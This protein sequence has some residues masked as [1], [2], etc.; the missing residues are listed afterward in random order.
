MRPGIGIQQQQQQHQA[1]SGSNPFNV[2]RLLALDPDNKTQHRQHY[3]NNYHNIN[4]HTQQHHHHHQHHQQHNNSRHQQH[5]GPQQR[6]TSNGAVARSSSNPPPIPHSHEPPPLQQHIPS[7]HRAMHHN[8]HQYDPHCGAAPHTQSV[9]INTEHTLHQQPIHVSSTSPGPAMTGNSSQSSESYLPDLVRGVRSRGSLASG[10]RE[11]SDTSSAYSGS[12]TMCHSVH[13][14]DHDDVDLS[15]LMESVVDSD[16]EDLAETI[17]TMAVRDAVRECLEKDPSERT[18]DDIKV[19]LEFTQRLKAFADKTLAVRRAMCQAMVFAVVEDAGTVLMNDGE[20]LDSWSVIINGHVQVMTSTGSYELHLGDSFGIPPTMDKLHH[21]GVMRSMVDDCQFVCIRQSDYYSI[22]HQGEENTQKVEEDGKLVL[23][24]EQR[25]I[26]AMNRKG[27]IVIKGTP[28]RLMLQLIEVENCIDPTYVEDFLLT[29]RTFLKSPLVVAEKLL[30]WFENQSLRNLVTRVVLL[31]VNNH[32]TDFEMDPVMMNFLEQFEEGLERSKMEGQLRLLDF[33]CAAKARSRTVTLTRPSR[34][35]I[36]HFSILGGL[37]KPYGI[38]ISKVEKGSKAEEVGLKRGDQILEVNGQS[39]EQIEHARAL[40]ILRS[41]CHLAI[42]VKSN[43]LAFKEMLQTPNTSPR[44]HHRKTSDVSSGSGHSNKSVSAEFASTLNLVNTL[45]SPRSKKDPNNHKAAFMT[46]KA[47]WLKDAIKNLLPKNSQLESGAHSDESV[48]SQSSSVGGAAFHSHSNPDLTAIPYEETRQEFPEHVLKVMSCSSGCSLV[49]V[50]VFSC[51]YE[52]TR[53][54][55]PEHV[56]K[57]MVFSCSY[58]E[59]RQEFPEHV[60]KVMSCSCRVF[61]CSLGVFSCS[62]EETR[63]EFPEHVLK[64]YRAS[65]QSAKFLPVHQETTAREVVMLALQ[66]F[67]INDQAGSS[68]YALY[69]VTVTEE[70]IRKQKRLPDRLQNLAERIGLSSRYYLKNIASSQNLVPDEIVHELIKESQVTFLQLNSVELAIQLTLEDFAIFRQIEPTEYIDHLFELKSKYGT[71]ALSQFAELVNREMFWVVTEVCSELNIVKR[72]KIIKQF[73]KVARQCKECKNFNSMFAILSGLGHRSVSRLRA[74]WERLPGKYHRLFQDLQ[75]LMDPS[76]NMSKYRNLIHD[77]A[78]Q[79][80]CIPFY[81]VVAK[82]LRFAHDGNEESSKGLINFETLRMISRYIRDLQSMCSTPYDLVSMVES[83]GQPVSTAMFAMNQMS[84]GQHH[85][86]V[87]RRNKSATTHD[88]KKMFEEAQMVRRVKAYLAKLSVTTDEDEL[89]KKSYLCEPG[90]SH[91]TAPTATS[92]GATS[93][94]SSGVASGSSMSS[95]ASSNTSSNTS[96]SSAPSSSNPQRRR[97]HSPTPSTTSSTSSTSHASDGRKPVKFGA[98][99]PQSM[100]K[101][102]ALAEAK[103]KPYHGPRPASNPLALTGASLSPGPSPRITRRGPTGALAGGLATITTSHL[104]AASNLSINARPNHERSHSDTPAVPVDLSAESSSV[105]TLSNIRKSHTQGTM[106]NVITDRKSLGNLRSTSEFSSVDEEEEDDCNS[107]RNIAK[108][109]TVSRD[110]S[111]VPIGKLNTK[112]ELGGN[113]SKVKRRQ[114][115]PKRY[116][117]SHLL[118]IT[119]RVRNKYHSR[120]SQNSLSEDISHRN[121]CPSHSFEPSFRD[122]VD[123]N[124][125]CSRTSQNSLS[126]DIGHRNRCPSHSFEPS[127]RD[128]VD[129]NFRYS[130]NYEGRKLMHCNT[131][132]AKQNS[133]ADEFP[134]FCASPMPENVFIADEEPDNYTFEFG[135]VASNCKLN[136]VMAHETQQDLRSMTGESAAVSQC[137]TDSG[138]STQYDCQSSNSLDDPTHSTAPFLPPPSPPPHH[139]RYS[140]QPDAR[141]ERPPFLNAVAVLP[142]LPLATNPP[143]KLGLLRPQV[144]PPLPLATNPP[145][146]LGLLRPQVLPPLPLA[147]YPPGKLGLLRPQVLP[148][149]PLATNPPGCPPRRRGVSA[150]APPDYPHTQM[151]Q[152]QQMGRAMSQDAAVQYYHNTAPQPPHRTATAPQHE[153]EDEAQ[154]SAV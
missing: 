123:G 77:D 138:I 50:G 80:P 130:N 82:D 118:S 56:L 62:Y 105:T 143:G 14:L 57:V 106:K 17:E 103:T 2:D 12:D 145:G 16:E 86:T 100:R 39:F 9:P 66:I 95:Q 28:E 109:M 120:T 70:G 94:T 42:T 135:N 97:P 137:E 1:R 116:F 132:P 96:S 84:A 49:L 111:V 146:K 35:E 140:Q 37:K 151:R 54:E 150:V 87:K 68:N 27:N 41:T 85:N 26:E 88:K 90:A 19:L 6:H 18:E 46:L 113:G 108:N 21:V 29:H 117:S 129:G 63:Q 127:F 93:S 92:S 34:D 53:Q 139:R 25:H 64:V 141:R 13:S 43:L 112:G 7:Q 125:R 71:P 78:T 59:T 115:A 31:W 79:P 133:S 52:E 89:E 47:H 55:F 136:Q 131:E 124:I 104:N 22:L 76:R 33:A 119:T 81:P 102:L 30:Q 48:S 121:R 73:I 32:F 65:D 144:L 60:L 23:V 149:L 134:S 98:G 11:G 20:E 99:S 67:N 148:P 107:E 8:N 24:M 147:T 38:F 154:V 69:E 152:L 110:Q 51:P 128:S 10:G 44:V 91:S 36:L 40:E 72:S 122:S 75:D 126:E 4:M 5:Y 3:G 142:P 153:D 61:S 101:I 83:G 45:A 114:S 58:E 15:G 74:T